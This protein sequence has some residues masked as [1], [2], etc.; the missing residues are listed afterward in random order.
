[1]SGNTA[2]SW[3]NANLLGQSNTAVWSIA[4][5]DDRLYTETIV[6]AGAPYNADLQQRSGA[7]GSPVG[8]SVPMFAGNAPTWGDFRG[9]VVLHPTLPLLAAAGGTKM[10]IK[11]L[12]LH[13]LGNFSGQL[14]AGNITEV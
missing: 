11:D 1:K 5:R 6:S 9:Q 4:A 3:L 7:D 8:A 2:S 10:R 12:D 13:D 14:A